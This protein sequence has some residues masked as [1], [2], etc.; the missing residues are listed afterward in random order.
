M[1]A[2]TLESHFRR[3][4]RKVPEDGCSFYLNRSQ[5]SSYWWIKLFYPMASY[6]HYKFTCSSYRM[7]VQRS[8]SGVHDTSYFDTSEWIRILCFGLWIIVRAFGPK[9][10]LKK[11]W[12]KKYARGGGEGID[13]QSP[14]PWSS[15]IGNARSFLRTCQF[16]LAL[17]FFVLALSVF[18]SWH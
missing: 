13:Q 2:G 17:S 15:A 16:V 14:P 5:H 10:P 1:Q 4:H 7:N 3:R 12:I 9:F 8:L 11:T 18:L 6:V